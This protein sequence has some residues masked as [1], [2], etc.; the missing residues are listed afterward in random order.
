MAITSL[1]I[2]DITELGLFV[3]AFLVSWKV[4][5]RHDTG[6][7]AAFE[8]LLVAVVFRV[9]GAAVGIASAHLDW[10]GIATAADVISNLTLPFLLAAAIELLTRAN[11]Q[12]W[13]K[14]IFESA[15]QLLFFPMI[16]A[17]IMSIIGRVRVH[18]N[19][20]PSWS[21]VKAASILFLSTL[22]TLAIITLFNIVRIGHFAHDEKKIIWTVAATTPLLLTRTIYEL[23]CAF[24]EGSRWFSTYS[25]FEGGVIVQ[26]IAGSL[27]EIL[28][29]VIYLLLGLRLTPV[30]PATE[31]R[32]ADVVAEEAGDGAS[33]SEP[34][35]AFEIRTVPPPAYITIDK[36]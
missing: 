35:S 18:Q 1:E 17:L 9:I 3:P 4:K 27:P 8:Y 22:V 6:K 20:T 24:A 23:L 10:S 16:V 36:K 28:T 30:R 25:S 29:V 11:G 5:R 33:L 19:D 7:V 21:L 13:S 31:V 34:A 12:I 26:A 14:G 2:L 15:I 32:E